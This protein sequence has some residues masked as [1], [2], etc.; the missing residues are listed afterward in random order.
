MFCEYLTLNMIL[1][2]KASTT[3]LCSPLNMFSAS[4]YVYLTSQ[5]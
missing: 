4:E 2:W 5:F 1:V 3:E